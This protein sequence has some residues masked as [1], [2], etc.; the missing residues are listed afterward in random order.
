M[1]WAT[2]EP[3]VGS[4]QGKSFLSSKKAARPVLGTSKRPILWV[5]VIFPQG[6]NGQGAKQTIPFIKCQNEERMELC[7]SVNPKKSPASGLYNVSEPRLMS[8]VGRL[9]KVVCA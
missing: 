8:Q 9:R 3:W 5:P 2:V 6:L 7:S 1:D 4:S